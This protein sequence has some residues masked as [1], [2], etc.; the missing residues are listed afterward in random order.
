[1]I[2]VYCRPTMP[3]PKIF[4]VSPTP[5]SLTE[6]TMAAESAGYDATNAISGRAARMPRTMDEK[7]T[8]FGGSSGRIPSFKPGLPRKLARAVGE[9]LGELVVGG[10]EGDRSR[11]LQPALS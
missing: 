8:V 6:R 11:P 7:S 4:T 10:E 3:P 1:M 9:I 5:I 2:G